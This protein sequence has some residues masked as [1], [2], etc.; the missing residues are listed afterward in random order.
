MEYYQ[1]LLITK[2]DK[3]ERVTDLSKDELEKKIIEPYEEGGLIFVNGTTINSYDL[4]RIHIRKTTEEYSKIS[5]R[6]YQQEKA[7][8]ASRTNVIDLTPYNNFED[9]F[10]TGEDVLD[11]FISGPVGYKVSNEKTNKKDNQKKTDSKKVF[12]VHGHN[13]EMK[14]STARFIEKF[15]LES[16]IL[17]EQPS[18]GKT[19]IEKFSDYSD[20][21]YAIVLLSA[22]D[23]AYVKNSDPE[24][25]KFRAR[26]N[27]ILELGYFLGK[28]GRNKVAA[29]Y[30]N[31]KD[32]EIPSDFSGVLYIGY[33][34]DDSW[35]LSLAKELRASGFN[36][37]MNKLI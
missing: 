37:D 15:N 20:V 14:Q 32:I 17:H 18:E 19:I 24:T 1:V 4:G 30:E 5:D 2:E 7:R 23:L 36:I 9:A 10:W 25:A 31:G 29:L 33:S 16:I 12:I 8:R 3:K 34:G 11:N 13:E 22:D 21:G 6:L 35:K 27:V 26:Q 28:L